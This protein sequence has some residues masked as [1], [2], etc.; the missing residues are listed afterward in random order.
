MN[1][2]GSRDT[3]EILEWSQLLATIL[4]IL[5]GLSLDA[6]GAGELARW[7]YGGA[8]LSVLVPTALSSARRRCYWQAKVEVVALLAMGAALWLREPLAGALV[9]VLLTSRRALTRYRRVRAGRRSA[10]A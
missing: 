9:A 3:V 8:T 10:A 7:F 4:G 5:S 1:G 6:L 2:G